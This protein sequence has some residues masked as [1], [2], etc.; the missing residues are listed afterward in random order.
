M[1]AKMKMMSDVFLSIKANFPNNEQT[2]GYIL[3][4]KAFKL[5]NK[6]RAKFLKLIYNVLPFKIN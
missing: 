2:Q 3:V 1:T 5:K 4:C 6:A